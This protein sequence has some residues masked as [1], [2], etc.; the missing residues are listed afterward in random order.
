MRIALVISGRTYDRNLV[1]ETPVGSF[2]RTESF[3]FSRH[4]SST[5]LLYTPHLNNNGRVAWKHQ[6]LDFLGARTRLDAKRNASTVNQA[7]W[8]GTRRS[9]RGDP[10]LGDEPGRTRCAA[11]FLTP[12]DPDDDDEFSNWPQRAV[13]TAS[14]RSLWP[15]SE[16]SS[17]VLFSVVSSRLSMYSHRASFFNFSK[18]LANS[19]VV[20][21][22]KSE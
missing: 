17:P 12:S 20:C 18:C 9:G 10:S 1:N 13:D 7:S 4:C 11:L 15:R 8:A 2:G 5:C 21:D 6:T 19:P 16:M 3:D 22:V 14:R